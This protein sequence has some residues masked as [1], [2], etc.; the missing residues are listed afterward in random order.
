MRASRRIIRGS[1][2]SATQAILEAAGTQQTAR[3][4]Y[5]ID[6][7]VR[8]FMRANIWD[9]LDIYKNYAVADSQL[10]L[11]NWKNPGTFNGTAVNSPTFTPYRGYTGNGSN[12]Y[13]TTNFNPATA[14]TPKFVQNSGT[15]F[16]RSLTNSASL[17][18]IW[19]DTSVGFN[20][21]GYVD[22]T[23]TAMRINSSST[24][25][26]ANSGNTIGLWS[27]TR[28]AS[29]AQELYKNGS[30]VGS[31]TSVSTAVVSTTFFALRS[32]TDYS[33]LQVASYGVGGHLDATKQAALAAIDLAYMT[34]V[35]AV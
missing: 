9:E 11:I 26:S 24:N 5:L 12:A 20:N 10:S 1:Y 2:H 33:P 6:Q 34:A 18:S 27:C 13:I 3:D 7:T 28:S 25:I 16:A 17:V 32:G 30:S 31:N 35:G 23:S 19:G 4:A 15:I 8:R 14:T 29:N 22:D 21:N